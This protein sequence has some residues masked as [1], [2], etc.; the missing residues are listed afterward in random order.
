MAEPA[1]NPETKAEVKV[2]TEAEVEGV[3]TKPETEAETETT[4][5]ENEAETKAASMIGEL[6]IDIEIKSTAEK[7]HHMFV[8]RP[9]HVPKA[10]GFIGGVELHEGEWGKVGSIVSWNYIHDGVPKVAKERIEA[11][12]PEKNLIKFRVL[13]GDVMKENKTFLLT[14]QVTPK[15]AGPGSV[16]KWHMEYER[17]DEKV[18]HPETLLP[19]FEAMSKEIDE[20]LLSTE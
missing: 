12:D 2:E 18:P 19:F 13:E 3:M 10:T 7:F 4:K 11:L 5:P 20:H 17:I 14:L 6:E 8:K 15:Q 9:H 1:T 16:V